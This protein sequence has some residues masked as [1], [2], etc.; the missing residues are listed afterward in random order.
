[1]ATALNLEMHI[2]QVVWC[3]LYSGEFSGSLFKI[4][5]P[6]PLAQMA[7]GMKWMFKVSEVS[8]NKMNRK[9]FLKL[10]LKNYCPS[11]HLLPFCLHHTS[12]SGWWSLHSKER[13]QDLPLPDQLVKLVWRETKIFPSQLRDVLVYV[14]NIQEATI[15]PK[16]VQ[17]YNF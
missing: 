1:M 13:P 15:K 14:Q 9:Y 6:W 11:I 16:R 2:M 8:E 4:S 5:S 12:G 7:W 10:N 3:F 17:S